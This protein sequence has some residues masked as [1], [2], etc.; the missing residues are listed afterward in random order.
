[1]LLKERKQKYALARNAENLDEIFEMYWQKDMYVI[2]Y[3][4][5]EVENFKFR[6]PVKFILHKF[7]ISPVAELVYLISKK[8]ENLGI[9][10]FCK[11]DIYRYSTRTT[12]NRRTC[13]CVANCN[14]CNKPGSEGGIQKGLCSSCTPDQPYNH[15]S[16]THSYSQYTLEQ[17]Y[18][19]CISNWTPKDILENVNA[20]E[21][22]EII[23][24]ALCRIKL[25]KKIKKIISS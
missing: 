1:M 21:L 8:G 2:K 23:M 20:Q 19:G 10:E 25:L 15:S 5:L 12:M 22:D 18:E 11:D 14:K 6:Y 24:H 16:S 9:C 17:K 13:Y 4:D 3:G 7:D